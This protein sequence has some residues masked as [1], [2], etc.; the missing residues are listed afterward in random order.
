MI[1]P[2][3]AISDSSETSASNSGIVPRRKI[4]S[5]NTQ[6]QQI[7]KNVFD[8][9]MDEKSLQTTKLPFNQVM[10]RSA[11]AVGM[12][13]QTIS[14]YFKSGVKETPDKKTHQSWKF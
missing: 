7:L 10:E 6:S 14:K 8:F 1:R 12:S 3:F 9:M 5:L 13:R 11:M 4:R 2:I